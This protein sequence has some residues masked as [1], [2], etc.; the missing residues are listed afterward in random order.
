MKKKRLIY[1]FHVDYS[2]R[3]KNVFGESVKRNEIGEYWEYS[4]KTV[5]RYAKKV[6]A[7]YIF[8]SP[9]E[10]EYKPHAFNVETFDKYRCIKYL[11]E[12]DQVL[13]IDT[14]VLIQPR[15]RNIFDTYL[16]NAHIIVFF[17]VADKAM[18]K[19]STRASTGK[20]N[21]GVILFNN[22]R[23]VKEKA[24]LY[25]IDIKSAH[26]RNREDPNQQKRINKYSKG[27][28]HE[29][30]EEKHA[31][32]ITYLRNMTP[33]D[34][35]FFHRIIDL[36][37]IPNFHLHRKWNFQFGK[38]T[39]EIEDAQF[40]HF[41]EEGKQYMEYA[42]YQLEIKSIEKILSELRKF[43]NTMIQIS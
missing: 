10:A 31:E 33:S 39:E 17:N 20:I 43:H 32:E 3:S 23:F 4:K 38:F 12:Y 28:W 9:T 25:T 1:Q 14:D 26:F 8:E 21:S 34:E 19:D 35:N 42:Y 37:G 13:Y 24:K 30:W 22:T 7:D 41:I 5:E 27:Y 40:I 18:Y 6:G 11:S 29:Y 2:D 15:A 16:D 36:Y